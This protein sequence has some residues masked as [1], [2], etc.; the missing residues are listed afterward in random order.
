M[1][2][3]GLVENKAN[4]A[5]NELE[6]GLSLAKEKKKNGEKSGPLTKRTK[7]FCFLF[8]LFF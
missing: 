3:V 4:S 6:L 5:P 8:F 1:G 7:T 2:V